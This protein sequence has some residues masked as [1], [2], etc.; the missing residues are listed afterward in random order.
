[1]HE[2][3]R[4]GGPVVEVVGHAAVE[5]L[6]LGTLAKKLG[7]DLQ[8]FL[9]GRLGTPQH[10]LLKQLV[11]RAAELRYVYL[12]QRLGHVD[13]AARQ[14]L[15]LDLARHDLPRQLDGAIGQIPRGNAVAQQAKLQSIGELIG[16]P[17]RS[18]GHARAKPIRR[19]SLWV[20]P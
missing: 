17:A 6:G 3:R 15:G 13:G 16:S 1:M 20:A 5:V 11:H 14:A 19:G 9:Q 7:L 18:S 12:G 8:P 4:R 2:L 10:R